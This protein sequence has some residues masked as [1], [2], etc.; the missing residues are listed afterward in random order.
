MKKRVL[1]TILAVCLLFSVMACGAGAA[2]TDIVVNDIVSNIRI[3][4]GKI[5]DENVIAEPEVEGYEKVTLVD[6]RYIQPAMLEKFIT[7]DNQDVLFLYSSSMLN[8]SLALK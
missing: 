2:V 7:F 4:P 3:C 1:A 5:L 6:I 8:N